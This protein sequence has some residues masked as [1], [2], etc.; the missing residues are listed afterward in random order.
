MTGHACLP[1]RVRFHGIPGVKGGLR[2]TTPFLYP[3]SVS[4]RGIRI[5][6]EAGGMFRVLPCHPVTPHPHGHTPFPRPAEPGRLRDSCAVSV[7]GFPYSKSDPVTGHG[8]N[9]L[10]HRVGTR[11]PH[12]AH[13]PPTRVLTSAQG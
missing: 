5:W 8:K 10:D 6:N 13:P 12:P 7:P 3:S 1:G 4:S 11:Y 9:G 2:D